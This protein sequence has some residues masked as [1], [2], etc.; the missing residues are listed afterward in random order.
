M[1]APTSTV[2]SRSASVAVDSPGMA[3]HPQACRSRE[4]ERHVHSKIAVCGDAE[5]IPCASRDVEDRGCVQAAHPNAGAP[6]LHVGTGS[7]RLEIV[8]V[9]QHVQKLG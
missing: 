5:P 2:A 7:V 1:C 4:K 8:P 6:L 3:G 9:G